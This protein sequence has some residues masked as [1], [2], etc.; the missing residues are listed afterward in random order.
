[1]AEG[2]VLWI[3]CKLSPNFP[4]TTE[5]NACCGSSNDKSK[6]YGVIDRYKST[7]KGI[8]TNKY[9]LIEMMQIDC[10]TFEDVLL[11]STKIQEVIDK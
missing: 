8:T 11:H 10:E 4:P 1:M 3:P 7:G 6:S 9:Y 2:S 5:R